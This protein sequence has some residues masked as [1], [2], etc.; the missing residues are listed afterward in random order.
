MG[1]LHTIAEFER[2]LIKERTKAGLAAARARGRLGVCPKK[3]D[4]KKIDLAKNLYALK[5]HT[6][7]EICDAVGQ[8]KATLYK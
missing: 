2:N 6:I 5:V 8:S 7:T 1:G 3:L 4:K